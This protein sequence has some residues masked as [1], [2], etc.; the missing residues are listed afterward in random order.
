MSQKCPFILELY[1]S[2]SSLIFKFLAF[3]IA[4]RMS[5]GKELTAERRAM[6]VG[7]T[8]GGGLLSPRYS[9]DSTTTKNHYIYCN[10]PVKILSTRKLGENEAY[11][12]RLFKTTQTDNCELV[13]W[14][15]SLKTH[16]SGLG[17]LVQLECLNFWPVTECLSAFYLSLSLLVCV[18]FVYLS[19]SLHL[20]LQV[21]IAKQHTN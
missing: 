8:K 2:V 16:L 13:Q 6:I 14:M 19:D 12:P 7:M 3:W 11:Y 10:D 17:L 9:R 5:K 21:L 4:L 20:K 1:V 15:A 18:Y